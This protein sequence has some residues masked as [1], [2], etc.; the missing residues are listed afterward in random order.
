MQRARRAAVE[1]QVKELE[2]VLTPR[3]CVHIKIP[4]E[5]HASLRVLGFQKKLSL[6]EMFVEISR[7][8]ADDDSYLTRKMDDLARLKKE[9]KIK[10]LTS[11]DS[12]DIYDYISKGG[13]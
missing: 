5:L 13:E 2:H 1:L 9:K 11:Q 8:L 6:Q 3:R 7:L 10:K 4:S 12:E